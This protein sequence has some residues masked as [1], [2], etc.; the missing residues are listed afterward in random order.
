MIWLIRQKKRKCPNVVLKGCI[1][2][3]VSF[4]SLPLFVFS[5]WSIFVIS[6]FLLWYFSV[7]LSPFLSR[8]WYLYALV[9]FLFLL[10]SVCLSG[11]FFLLSN[12]I[13]LS[14]FSGSEWHCIVDVS[15]KL[16]CQMNIKKR[17]LNKILCENKENGQSWRQIRIR[18]R[19]L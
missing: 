16:R 12:L 17:T 15:S 11:I 10:L 14:N 9:S 13:F 19:R 4:L 2:F 8:Y 7:F 3:L 18:R 1:I 5:L 6:L